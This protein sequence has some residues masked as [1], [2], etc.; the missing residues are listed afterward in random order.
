MAVHRHL[1][2]DYQCCE[3]CFCF[4]LQ[5]YLKLFLPVRMPGRAHLALFK[6]FQLPGDVTREI[7]PVGAYF[8]QK[9]QRVVTNMQC[10]QQQ[11]K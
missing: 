5:L 8:R 4:A 1:A 9:K 10:W 6:Y 7:K 3:R 11:V 2:V